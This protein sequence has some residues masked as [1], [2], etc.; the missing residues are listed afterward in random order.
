MK[1]WLVRW[2]S[3][4]DGNGPIATILSARLGA[5]SVRCRVEQ[6]HT[7]LTAFIQEKLDY[8][9]YSRPVTPPYRAQIGTRWGSSFV[10]CG[11]NPSLMAYQV[12][13]LRIESG[14][15]GRDVLH[16][17]DGS[18]QEKYVIDPMQQIAVLAVTS[19]DH[20]RLRETLQGIL[21]DISLP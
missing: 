14:K 4:N 21:R 11:H 5:E 13:D 16:W 8:S 1:A 6:L 2:V 17:V 20:G 7:D 18:Q 12:K 10:H 19:A 15:D 9:H 3:T